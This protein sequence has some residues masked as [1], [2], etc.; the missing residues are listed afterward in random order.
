MLFRHRANSSVTQVLPLF[1][2]LEFL[3]FQINFVHH[4]FDNHYA[5]INELYEARD[6]G[7]VD[8]WIE[9]SD[10]SLIHVSCSFIC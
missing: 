3:F 7:G 9:V 1:N 6:Y 2:V 4:V 10:D 5:I 8:K